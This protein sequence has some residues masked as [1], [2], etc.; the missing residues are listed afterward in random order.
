MMDLTIKRIQ[1]KIK[2]QKKV[3]YAYKVGL[4]IY[5]FI[6][7][8]VFTYLSI[9]IIQKKAEQGWAELFLPNGFWVAS[10]VLLL[11][12]GLMQASLWFA[13]NNDINN[14][15]YTLI[16]TIA[17]ALGVLASLG[18]AWRDLLSIVDLQ[19][20]GEAYL[21]TLS[22]FYGAQ[23]LVALMFCVSV[24][25]QSFHY[26]VHSKNM[27]A[28]EMVGAYITFLTLLWFYLLMFIQVII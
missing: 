18:A 6:A 13:R 11:F 26:K 28:I 9:V 1:S 15:Q 10:G 14:L 7:I 5:M 12:G 8:V 21:L 3:N 4:G 17:S 27:N 24:T 23:F 20:K 2:Y 22:G 25:V 19:S 16:A